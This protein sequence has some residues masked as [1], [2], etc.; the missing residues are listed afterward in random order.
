MQI[1]KIQARRFLLAYQGL[2]PPRK[3]KGK[4]GILAFIRQVG[5]IQYDPLDI[6]GNNP[7]LVLQSR[8]QGYRRE[9]LKELLY[10]DRKLL[11]GWDKMMAIYPVEDW[12]YFKRTRESFAKN[13]SRGVEAIDAV[14]P[15]VRE[16]L[17]AKGPL[18][19]RELALGEAL[20]WDWGWPASLA[21]AALESMYFMGELL[22]HHRVHTRKYY[23]FAHRLVEEA[24]LEAPDPNP[25]EE[26]Y[27]DWYVS[28]R[29]GSVG[30]L[31][32]RAG[33]AWLSLGSIKSPQRGRVIERL[34]KRGELLQVQ[35]EGIR[36]PFYLR[37]Q[38]E[39]VLLEA[40]RMDEL[41]KR[42]AL[43]A[44]L[45][46]LL[47]D[48]RMLKELF[49]F[50]YRWEVYV[51]AEKRRYGYYV[52]PLLYGD[53]FIA[54][55]EPV[56]DKKRGVLAVKNWWWEKGVN[57]SDEIKA[58]LGEC[59]RSFFEYSGAEQLEVAGEARAQVGM[60]WLTEMAGQNR[61]EDQV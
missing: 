21:R 34:L 13:R 7:D 32:N 22:I 43:I 26:A 15:K 53:R 9:M 39:G 57:P 38:D 58:A 56:K 12:P 31:W 52:L 60:D 44:P 59:M 8:V 14:L 33:E 20:E 16:A 61:T 51:P 37:D 10:E 1:T 25:T 28:R 50:D 24:V 19:S 11:D 29:I 49:D 55:F 23:D 3:L 18:S 35:V 47:W 17:E 48:R 5:C 40:M 46:N 36:D 4:T 6:V 27:Q 45:D 2:L 41:E 30:M 42:A 54:R